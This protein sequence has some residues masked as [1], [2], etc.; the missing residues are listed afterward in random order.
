MK[1]TAIC[2][3]TITSLLFGTST[4]TAQAVEEG[5][6]IVD[7]YYGFPN[8]YTAVFKATYA[9]SGSEVDLRIG[10]LGPIGFRGEYMVADKVGVGLDVGFNNSFVSYSENTTEY[11][12]TTGNYD[13]VTYDYDFKTS[14]IG[15]MATFNYHFLDNDKVDAYVVFGAGYGNRT[16]KFTSTD[17]DY[18]STDIKGAIPVASRIGVGMRYFLTDNIG[19]NMGIGFGQGGIA[20]AGVSFKF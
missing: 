1:K 17:P 16:F 18:V 6:V 4:A 9:N 10:G 5:N 3:M 13:P 11:N 8:L 12:T 20:N 7:L 2:L 14:K 19:L 15:V